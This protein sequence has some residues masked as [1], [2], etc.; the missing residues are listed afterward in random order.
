[1][2][3]FAS[4]VLNRSLAELRGRRAKLEAFIVEA[5]E[6]DVAIREMQKVCR[7]IGVSDGAGPRPVPA[8][9]PARS[10]SPADGTNV[11]RGFWRIADADSNAA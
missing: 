5:A 2:S 1:M 4:E 7:K 3:E 10:T 6:L 9:T 11:G 8:A